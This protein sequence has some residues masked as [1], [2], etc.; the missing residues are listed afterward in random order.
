MAVRS[1]M[2]TF[3]LCAAGYLWTTMA[4]DVAMAD[5]WR[6]VLDCDQ[7]AAVLDLAEAGNPARAQLVIRS[8]EIASYLESVGLA[9]HRSGQGE[10]LY[11]F[12]EGG[13]RGLGQAEFVERR[14]SFQRNQYVVERVRVN[15]NEL[16]FDVMAASYPTGGLW[17]ESERIGG[18]RFGSC[19]GR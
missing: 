14:F 13:F 6:A 17:E 5:S 4:P 11:R 15:G 8:R 18:W 12:S 3:S 9:D 1:L 10:L 7:G 16:V 2:T 19:S